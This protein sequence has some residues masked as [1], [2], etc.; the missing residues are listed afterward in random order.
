MAEELRYELWHGG[1]HYQI[2][3]TDLGRLRAEIQTQVVLAEHIVAEVV[4]PYE[5]IAHG[6]PDRVREQMERQHKDV[7][8]RLVANEFDERAARIGRGEAPTTWKRRADQ[9][10]TDTD[11]DAPAF[12][13]A[14]TED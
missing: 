5:A 10:P 4:L 12:D 13:L 7:M 1:R 14:S 11:F 9:L 2:S 3:T 8:R 6:R